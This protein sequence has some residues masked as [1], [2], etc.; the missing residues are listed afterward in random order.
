M[1]QVDL[2]V[3]ALMLSTACASL[4]RAGSLYA[5]DGIVIQQ[6]TSS[7]STNAQLTFLLY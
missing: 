3:I 5:G 4:P 1:A 7:L 6:V 2:C